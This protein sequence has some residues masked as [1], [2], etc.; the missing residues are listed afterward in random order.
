MVA[1]KLLHDGSVSAFDYRCEGGPADKPYT[2]QHLDYSV[3]YVRGAVS[4]AAAGESIT[5]SSP[6]R[7]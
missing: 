7:C 3:S 5:S 6:D 4:A 2:E 1:A